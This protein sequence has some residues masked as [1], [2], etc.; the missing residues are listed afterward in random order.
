MASLRVF[1]F[2]LLSAIVGI[3]W[4]D[5]PIE[6]H[7]YIITN[8]QTGNVVSNKG[9]ASTDAKLYVEPFVEGNAT[10]IWK[11][12]QHDY[13][14]DTMLFQLVNADCGLAI[15]L[16]LN[17]NRGPLLW[18][19]NNQGVGQTFN[20]Q[21][22]EFVTL[23]AEAGTYLLRSYDGERA[24]C[25]SASGILSLTENMSSAFCAFTLTEAEKP[26]VQTK[27][28]EDSSIFEENKEA[29]HAT[30][31]PYPTTSAMRADAERYEKPWLDPVGAK[32]LSLNGV[33]QLN[34]TTDLS[35]LPAEADFYGDAADVSAWD[36]ISVPSCLEMKGYGDPLYINVNYPFADNPPTIKMSSGL[37]NSVASYRRTF[38]LPMGWEK[39]RVFLHFDGIYS[40]AYVWVNGH[41]V[42][43]TQGAN[44][45]SEFDVSNVVR[46]GEN[47][48]SVRVIRWTDGSYLEGQDM[49]HMSGIHRDVYLFATPRTFIADHRITAD[50]TPSGGQ[51]CPVVRFTMCNRDRT[52]AKKIV[53]VTLRDPE[54]NEMTSQSTEIEMTASDSIQKVELRMGC[55]QD[56]KLW[57]SEK[58]ILY[59]FEF[60][61]TDAQTGREEQ[62]FST[63]YGFRSIDLNMG[64]LRVNGQRVYLKG[65][66]TQ[67][68]H[69]MHGRT[70]PVSTMLQDVTLM[71]QANINC[72]R[73]SHYPRQAKMMAM[74][75]YFGLYCVDEADMEC[76]KNWED[77]SSI[78]NS[79]DWTAAI[80]D[81][82]VRNVLR[83]RNHPSVVMWSLGNE[84]GSGYN[85]IAAYDAVSELDDRPIH[86]EGA[87]R[88]NAE[89]TDVWSVMYPNVGDVASKCSS[90]WR[91]QPYF[92]CEYAH[93]M[94]NSVG[95]LAEYWG[96]I[97]GSTYGIGGCIWD[98]VDQSIYDAEDIKAGKLVQNGFPKYITGYDKPGPHQGNFVNNGIVNAD[99][100]WSPE[101]YTVKKVYQNVVRRTF[102]NKRLNIQNNYAFTN[103]NEF[104][105]TW[106]VLKDGEVVESGSE[107]MT[108][109][110]AGRAATK[111]MSY[112]TEPEVGSEY[113]LNYELR[114]REATPWAEAGYAVATFQD[115]IQLRPA[116]LPTMEHEGQPFTY[117]SISSSRHELRNDRVEV[118]FTRNGLYTYKVDG[119]LRMR[120]TQTPEY[121]DYRYIENEEPYG[122]TE[123]YD[124]SP[125]VGDKTTTYELSDDG[126]TFT[127]T[128]EADGKKVPYTL[129]Y[130]LYCDGVVE[131]EA[132]FS[133]IANNLRR[134]GLG[135]RFPTRW[136]NITYYACGPHENYIDRREGAYLGVYST[137]VSDMFEPYARPQSCGNHEGLRWVTL[138]SADGD[139][140]RVETEG[141]VAFSMLH[142]DDKALKSANHCWNLSNSGEVFAHFD[143]MQKGLGNASCGPG[144]LSQYMVP[145]SGTYGYKLRFIP[146]KVEVDGINTIDD[147]QG[148]TANGQ[149]SMF[150][151][152][153]DLQGRRINGQWPAYPNET[154]DTSRTVNRQLPKG[155]YI[156]NGKKYLK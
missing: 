37:Q 45:V 133:P 147:E 150:N 124:T 137:T 28:W 26:N 44:N 138:S 12:V 106:S 35:N 48:V 142:W 112:K 22:I 52:A 91:R 108:S 56:V 29:G 31:M 113:L 68:T 87:T 19:V 114:L 6:G 132:S 46:T 84:S 55:H 16:S 135:M 18:T 80:V 121:A 144:P 43:Y 33:W 148:S 83:D 8:V 88:G 54:G 60:S 53:R 64:Y 50:V 77:G 139:G 136:D 89:G 71:K 107:Q 115:T 5:K 57:S 122:G 94:G 34:W 154:L 17:T 134:I 47:N 103:L 119:V 13:L 65:V 93:A 32:W 23:N 38:T 62:A 126:R 145:S 73:T 1:I 4:A 146:V 143:Y 72:V 61:Q 76:H 110:P 67:D 63:R 86:Y 118:V 41:Y 151:G 9:N 42:G 78:I 130:T 66:N 15:D 79:S 27:Y 82:N 131:L 97:I 14:E 92:M 116:T 40:A 74:F 69:P 75:D 58:P 99:R 11:F 90:N 100:S 128:I 129:K 149:R 120:S 24:I 127:C 7:Y 2:A 125:G 156:R 111:L 85:V 70:M 95:N 49:W 98:W 102:R 10:Q 117:E 39:E 51:A 104:D 96:A 30:Y 153:Y 25:A 21:I 20:N 109:C 123:N 36:T 155:I 141:N 101:L 3:I 59:T 105:L 152:T 140:I 81:R